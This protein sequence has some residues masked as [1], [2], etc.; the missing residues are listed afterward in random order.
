ML[1]FT[2][3]PFVALFFAFEDRECPGTDGKLHE[4][5][6]RAVFAVSSS[7]IAEH[8]AQDNPAPRPFSPSRETS[9]RLTNQ[10]GLFLCMPK[11]TDLE[12]YVRQHFQGERPREIV[13]K[14]VITNSGRIDCLKHLNK[15]NINR[16]ALFPDLD[17]AAKYIDGLWELDFDTSFGYIPD[18]E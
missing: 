7:C 4:P 8:Q 13:R 6:E 10:A 14:I 11:N 17:G 1:D 18:E 12:S 3:S 2:L 9:Y 5:Q 15:M 16:M